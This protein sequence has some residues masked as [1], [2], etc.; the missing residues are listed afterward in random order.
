MSRIVVVGGGLS[1]LVAAYWATEAGLEVSVLEA[2]QGFG[3]NTKTARLDGIALELGEEFFH[4]TPS[5]LYDLC[6][7]LGLNPQPLPRHRRIVR[8]GGQDWVLPQ[9]LN[10]FSGHGLHHITEMPFS[11]SAK[12]RLNTERFVGPALVKNE[13]AGTFLRRRLGPEVWE[14]LEPYLSAVLGGPAEEVSASAA[15]GR[16]LELERQGGLLAGSRQ[17]THDGRF[18][19][20]DGRFHLE[21]G[22]G[23]LIEALGIHLLQKAQLLPHH[24]AWAITHDAKGWQV[25][26]RGGKVEAEAVIVAL[27]APQAAKVF[28]PSAPQMTTLLNHFPYQHS[29]KVYLL[30]RSDTPSAEPKEYF[31]AKGEGYTCTALKVIYPSE[32]IMLVQV[33]FAGETARSADGELSRLAQGEAAKH[34]QTRV[35]PRAAW[36]FRQPHSRPHFTQGHDRRVAD[37]ERALVHAPGLFLTG[38]YLAGPGLAHLVEHS[39]KTTRHAL[40]F[41][42]LTSP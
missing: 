24:Q 40:D 39:Y 41:L 21:T 4:D 3:G 32:E 31:F 20:H 2:T 6:T 29:A 36:V 7:Q 18:H 25:H 8:K 9:D 11:R 37:L 10:L 13:P 14:V 33:Q 23:G 12:W 42:A 16:L 15:F 34:L 17:L 38:S 28:R 30:Y 27:P 22:M 26:V 1:G 35:P 5:T 19:P